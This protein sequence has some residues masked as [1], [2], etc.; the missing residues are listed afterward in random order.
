[1]K[2]TLCTM[3]PWLDISCKANL[4][5]LNVFSDD[6]QVGTLI[7]RL[8]LVCLIIGQALGEISTI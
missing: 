6:L 5:F 2:N 8:Y 3:P 1:M 7:I 4:I